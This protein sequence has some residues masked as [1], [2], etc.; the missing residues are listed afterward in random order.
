MSTRSILPNLAKHLMKK[1]ISEEASRLAQE[2]YGKYTLLLYMYSVII[3]MWLSVLSH[4]ISHDFFFTMGFN[5]YGNNRV[6]TMEIVARNN[7]L[8]QSV[9]THSASNCS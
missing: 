4:L 8:F 2:K 3:F 5:R 7:K 9:L 6:N 1:R